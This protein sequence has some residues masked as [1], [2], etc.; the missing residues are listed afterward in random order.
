LIAF[1]HNTI[2]KSK[3]SVERIGAKSNVLIIFIEFNILMISKFGV[4]DMHEY[5]NV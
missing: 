5:T 3:F 4:A 1:T 2:H